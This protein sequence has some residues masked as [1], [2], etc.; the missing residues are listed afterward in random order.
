M[1]SRVVAHVQAIAGRRRADAVRPQH[2]LVERRRLAG[3]PHVQQGTRHRLLALE[4]LEAQ[5]ADEELAVRRGGEI[6]EPVEPGEVVAR[7]QYAVVVL[8]RPARDH[9]TAVAVR[10][11]PADAASLRHHHLSVAVDAAAGHVAVEYG[12]VGGQA[13]ALEE[14]A[15]ALEHALEVAEHGSGRRGQGRPPVRPRPG[16]LELRREREQQRLAGRRPGEL[17]AD[18]QAVRRLVEG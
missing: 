10:H 12:S 17:D 2:G 14:L 15:R 13:W 11:Q 7:E 3:R 18:R 9:D 16:G 6:V 1:A 4:R 8:H 5:R